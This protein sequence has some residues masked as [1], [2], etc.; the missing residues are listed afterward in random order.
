MSLSVPCPMQRQTRQIMRRTV[1]GFMAVWLSGFVFLFCCDAAKAAAKSVESCPMPK[2]SHHCDTAKQQ[3]DDS[4][5][6]SRAEGVCFECC[7]FLPVVFDKARKVD[8]PNQPVAAPDRVVEVAR[9]I[10]PRLHRTVRAIARYRARLPDKSRTFIST[11][12]FRI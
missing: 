3:N 4:N 8:Q 5:S 9:R 10:T 7:A 2:M 6:V 1:A 12:V 11:Q